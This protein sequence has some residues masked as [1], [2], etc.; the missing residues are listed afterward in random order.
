MNNFAIVIAIIMVVISCTKPSGNGIEAKRAGSEDHSG[1][2]HLDENRI[3]SYYTCSMHPQIRENSPGKCPI[4]GM[5]LVKVEVE[6]DDEKPKVT[7]IVQEWRCKD[8]PEVTSA[9]DE[10]CPIDGSPMILIEQS[11]MNPGDAIAEVKL[12]KSQLSHFSPS[13]FP[14]TTMR[15]TKSIRLLG[16]VMQSEEKESTIP[17][18]V[19][20]R[21]E[22]VY[23]KSTGSFIQKGDPVVQLYSPKLITTGQEYIVS[24]NSYEE[25]RNSDFKALMENAAERLESFGI[26]K[27]QYEAWY[28]KKSVPDKIILY[29][30][31]S[32]IVRTKNATVG[33]YFKEGQNLFEITD[34]SDVWVELDVYEHDSAIVKMNQSVELKFSSSPG[35]IIESNIDFIAPILDSNSRTLKVRATI[36]NPDGVL[37]PGMIAEANLEVVFEGKP[38]VIPRTAIINTGKR[39]VV[40]TKISEKKFQA[41]IVHTG[42]ESEGYVEIKHG[43]MENEEV[44]IDGNFLLDAQAQLFGGYSDMTSKSSTHQH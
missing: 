2:L 40:W 30:H 9:S 8:Y 25:N 13:Y 22:K 11:A 26:R 12:R 27:F 5:N 38:L 20:G 29:S 37:K 34:L 16:S 31:T 14:V 44:I 41:K 23:P 17:A 35:T 39:K 32:G 28:K 7:P 15:M 33:K 43:L 18:R 36:A 21:V 24:R 4:C 6:E 10:P 3:S 1:H 42:F 19:E